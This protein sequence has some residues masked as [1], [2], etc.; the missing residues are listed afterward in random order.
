MR[1]PN[2]TMF[3]YEEPLS[4]F[5]PWAAEVSWLA[6]AFI[7]G[8]IVSFIWAAL[9]SRNERNGPSYGSAYGWLNHNCGQVD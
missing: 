3:P 1:L 4:K 2:E 9:G 6:G 5:R 8:V 7:T